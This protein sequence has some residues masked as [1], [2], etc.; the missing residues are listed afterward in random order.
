M[1]IFFGGNTS[2]NFRNSFGQTDS[3]NHEDYQNPSINMIGAH[4]VDAK[5]KIKLHHLQPANT[6]I[7]PE[8]NG[9]TCKSFNWI[10]KCSCSHSDG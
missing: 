9:L 1:N 7:C 3:V 2:Q 5:W 8:D 4:Q 6:L 10:I